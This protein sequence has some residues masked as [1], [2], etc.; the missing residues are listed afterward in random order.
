M[1]AVVQQ[2]RELPAINQA[3]QSLPMI[4]EGIRNL[5][6]IEQAVLALIAALEPAL[7]DLHRVREIVD[8]QQQQV[9]HV[10]EMMQA[11]ERRS[12][13][14]ERAVLGLKAQA[15]EAM[16]ALPDPDDD[17]GAIAKARDVLT[18]AT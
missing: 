14:L 3:V 16:R 5:P 2:I 13:V 17:R 12:A 9:T 1:P 6:V 11:I 15:D 8:V 4:V 18:G 10:E 7:L